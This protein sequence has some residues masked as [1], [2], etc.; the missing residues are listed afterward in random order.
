[1]DKIID[2]HTFHRPI[3]VVVGTL[4][5]NITFKQIYTKEAIEE[6]L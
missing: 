6:D 2:E 5:N 4:D 3:T 1:M